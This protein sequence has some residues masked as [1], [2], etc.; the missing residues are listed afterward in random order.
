[1][2]KGKNLSESEKLVYILGILSKTSKDELMKEKLLNIKQRLEK[3][4]GI[5]TLVEDEI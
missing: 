1:M 2:R 4:M 3:K 5:S